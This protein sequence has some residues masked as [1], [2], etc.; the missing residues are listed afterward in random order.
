MESIRLILRI[1]SAAFMENIGENTK[2]R[3]LDETEGDVGVGEG[4]HDSTSD[5]P[6]KKQQR[7]D[8]NHGKGQNLKQENPPWNAFLDGGPSTTKGANNV[9]LGVVEGT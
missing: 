9:Q 7:A 2:K 6:V 5:F 4:A 1:A 3:K 8:S